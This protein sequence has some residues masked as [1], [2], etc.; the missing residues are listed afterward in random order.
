MTDLVVVFDIDD[1]L[2]FERDYVESGFRHVAQEVAKDTP[3]EA[4]AIFEYLWG[5]FKN[6]VRGDTFDRLLEENPDVRHRWTVEALV[7]RYREH[8]PDIEWNPQMKDVV[9]ELDSQFPLAVLSDGPL[10][11]QRAKVRGLNL[12]EHFDPIILTREVAADAEKPDPRPFRR[13]EEK[14]AKSGT[15]LV[16]LADNPTK[17]FVAPNELGWT[18]IRYRDP[19]QLRYDIE[20]PNPDAAPDVVIEEPGELTEAMSDQVTGMDNSLD[21]EA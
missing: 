9:H 21:P 2:Y 16:Y 7:E 19:R 3:Y 8:E 10:P 15:S 13:A 5:L 12:E 17:D 14:T 20:P 4:E 18:T 6:G 1:T 11:S